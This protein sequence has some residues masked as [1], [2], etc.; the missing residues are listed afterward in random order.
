MYKINAKQHIS[1][2]YQPVEVSSIENENGLTSW[3]DGDFDPLLADSGCL[4]QLF[5]NTV[6][7]YPE[8]FAVQFNSE[9]LTYSE[10]NNK[11]NRLAHYLK[12][13]GV[14][15]SDYAGI[16]L[17]RTPDMYIAM[18]GILKA[19]AAYIPI[20]PKYPAERVHFILTNCNAKIIIST[21]DYIN[22]LTGL[23]CLSVLL[24]K[25]QNKLDFQSS[26]NLSVGE[27]KVKSSDTAYVIYTSGTTGAPKGVKISHFA[28][29]NL[30]R[31][32]GKIF[33]VKQEDKVFQGF[34]V[35]F[36][37]SVEEIWLAFYSGATIFVGTEEIMQ[38]G[39]NLSKI[40]N[41]N[42]VTVFSTV[43]TLLSI[44]TEDIPLLRLLILGG[45]VCPTELAKR[46]ATSGR[47][48]INTYGP[49]ET[50]VI[51]TYSECSP[52]RNVTIG[53]PI[54]NYSAYILDSDMQKVPVCAAG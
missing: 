46:W 4:H 25:D 8:S 18:L 53:K 51:A 1:E 27:T 45:E 9:T 34:S 32:E 28:V 48:M 22:K 14:G 10:L 41:D 35:A 6:E 54:P 16:L 26:L 43:P 33:G 23:T 3:Y 21:S 44:L 15:T 37:A 11:A 19:G 47:R 36:D 29:C 12:S 38:S 17:S 30:V 20:D 24:D 49:T 31:A 42:R 7:N 2:I 50:T 13:L 39:S 52:R 5:E 40:L